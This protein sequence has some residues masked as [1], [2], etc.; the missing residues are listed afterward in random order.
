MP[1]THKPA[2]VMALLLGMLIYIGWYLRHAL[3]LVYFSIVIAALL[4]GFV[5]RITRW[6]IG[7]WHPTRGVGVLVL[8]AALAGVVALFIFVML[9]PILRDARAMVTQLPQMLQNL[10]E[11][12]GGLPFVKK[13]DPATVEAYLGRM[14]GGAQGV[15][16]RLAAGAAEF[17]AIIVLSAYFIIDGEQAYRWMLSMLPR[18][19]AGRLD[20]TLTAGVRRMRG[21]LTGQGMLMLI[22]GVSA[23]IAFGILRIKFFYVLGVFA[24]VINIIPVVGPVL[25]MIVAGLVAATQSISKMLGVI[26]FFLLYHNAENIFLVPRI[27]A[28]EVKMPG[29]TVIA[30]LLIGEQLAGM[31]GVLLAVPT[32]V[33][34][35][36]IVDEYLFGCEPAAVPQLRRTA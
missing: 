30:A 36:E 21:W 13:L 17:V 33:L 24:G 5:D 3:L 4:G 29:V 22:H 2:I 26:V 12:Y 8:A 11:H 32:A 35:S 14:V 28:S 15:A 18:D 27:M 9:P 19:V 20:R 7:R 34:V 10:K 31:M 25:T 23:T 16:Q 1:R 6:R